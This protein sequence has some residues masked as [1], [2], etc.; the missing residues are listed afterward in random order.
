MNR[1]V[2]SFS[3]PAIMLLMASP[4][5]ALPQ[6]SDRDAFRM[7]YGIQ[8]ALTAGRQFT[9]DVKQLS[10][11]PDAEEAGRES[12]LAQQSAGVRK[13]ELDGIRVARAAARSM[14]IPDDVRIWFAV[15]GSYLSKPAKPSADASKSDTEDV[16]T[17]LAVLDETSEFASATKDVLP[18]IETSIKL[19]AGRSGLWSFQAGRIMADIAAAR[20]PA[21][22]PEGSLARDL[23]KT[24]PTGYEPAIRERLKALDAST[25]PPLSQDGGN[26]SSLLPG[27]RS[28]FGAANRALAYF[29][30][31]YGSTDLSSPQAREPMMPQPAQ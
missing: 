23:A 9:A 28:R 5:F 26:L 25:T 22:L 15:N 10:V 21:D 6:T 31:T 11:V 24:M 17:V 14:S 12:E 29:L 27:S 3:A 7:G 20:L 4:V 8:S 16:K 30:K 1:T 19:Q 13:H 2:T 18:S